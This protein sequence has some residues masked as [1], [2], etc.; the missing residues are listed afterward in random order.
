MPD[1]PESVDEID[2]RIATL[3]QNLR[4]LVEQAAA[5]SGAA[6][7][8]L[9][10]QRIADQEAELDTLTRKRAELAGPGPAATR[11]QKQ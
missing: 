11:R 8:D 5:H 1:V 3:R 6:D 2:Q 9:T 7:D 10:A 4:D